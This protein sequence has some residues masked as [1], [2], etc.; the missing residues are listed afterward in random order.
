ML[1]VIF[2]LSFSVLILHVQINAESNGIAFT[3]QRFD[4]TFIPECRNASVVNAIRS[5]C[6]IIITPGYR[7]QTTFTIKHQ[8]R[9]NSGKKGQILTTNCVL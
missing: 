1:I 2:S 3:I 9:F 7:E 5:L 8:D 4:E 6:N